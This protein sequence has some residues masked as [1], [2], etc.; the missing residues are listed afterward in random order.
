MILNTGEIRGIC[1]ETNQQLDV[2]WDRLPDCLNDNNQK[3]ADYKEGCEGHCA[4]DGWATGKKLRKR[5]RFMLAQL[6]LRSQWYF[7]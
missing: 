2:K 5:Q 7:I 1:D 4:I 6:A 3:I